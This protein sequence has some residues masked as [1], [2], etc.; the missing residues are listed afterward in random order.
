[1]RNEYITLATVNGESGVEVMII[2]TIIS[3]ADLG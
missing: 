2:L 1:M 3:K